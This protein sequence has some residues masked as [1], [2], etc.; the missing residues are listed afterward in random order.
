MSQSYFTFCKTILLLSASLSIPT[1][2][3]QNSETPKPEDVLP[4]LQPKP[5]QHKFVIEFPRPFASFER[6]WALEDAL[7]AALKARNAGTFDGPLQAVDGSLT[8]FYLYS[9]DFL[10]TAE[11]VRPVLREHGYLVGIMIETTM[12]L[13]NGTTDVKRFELK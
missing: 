6:Q 5:N 3:A 7:I 10:T 11:A 4:K 9:S 2:T 8:Q 13:E 1:A 12:Q